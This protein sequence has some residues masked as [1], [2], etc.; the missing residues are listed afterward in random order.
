MTIMV[1]PAAAPIHRVM[2]LSC[3]VSGVSSSLVAESMPEIL[4]TSVSAPVPVTIITPL[5]WVTGVFMNA[6]SAWSPGPRSAP[7]TVVA[8]LPAGTLSPVRADS[9]ICRAL[10]CDDAAVG[11]D[12]VAGRQQHHVA[13]DHFL[14]LDLRLGAVPAHPRGGLHHRLERVHGALGLALFAQA[15]HGVDHR[16][17]QEH[18]AGVELA[19]DHGEDAGHEQDDLHVGP[20]LVEEPAPA[21]LGLLGRQGVGAVLLEEVGRRRRGQAGGRVDAEVGRHLLGRAGVPGLAL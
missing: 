3:L 12:L 16:E 17:D 6:M 20:V 14:R 19:D 2:R 21:G 11:G 4:P 10:A 5:P 13:G 7:V 1:R 15:D 8:S 9:S 18:D